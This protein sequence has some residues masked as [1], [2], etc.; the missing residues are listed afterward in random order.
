M[1]SCT[2]LT[3]Y[4]NGPG[5]VSVETDGYGRVWARVGGDMKLQGYTDEPLPYLIEV[6]GNFTAGPM[7]NRCPHIKARQID[8]SNAT[9]LTMS[10]SEFLAKDVIPIKRSAFNHLSKR[11]RRCNKFRFT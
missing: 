1:I 3:R 2:D 10:Q 4:L 8:L 11:T 9:V 5:T 6:A 7:A